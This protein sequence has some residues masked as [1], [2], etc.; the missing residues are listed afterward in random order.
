MENPF[1]D[2]IRKGDSEAVK[3]KELFDF[4]VKHNLSSAELYKA[5][6]MALSASLKEPD[7]QNREPVREE[8]IMMAKK[9]ETLMD[10]GMPLNRI[11]ELVNQKTDYESAPEVYRAMVRKMPINEK[12]KKTLISI[13]EENRAGKLCIIDGETMKELCNVIISNRG[14]KEDRAVELK[15]ILSP[16]K[17]M[18]V[19]IMFSQE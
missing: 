16:Y 17:N 14:T 19:E 4:T 2:S 3:I 15:Y 11:V 6:E 13:M 12:G 8:V 1:E 5:Y 7:S 18:K 9:M 10:G